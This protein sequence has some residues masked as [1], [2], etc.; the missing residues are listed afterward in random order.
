M[1]FCDANCR[2]YADFE[3][4][5]KQ[6]SPVAEATGLLCDFW[7]SRI[8]ESGGSLFGFDVFDGFW[9]D[10]GW[11]PGFEVGAW[12]ASWGVAVFAELA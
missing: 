11:D 7:L 2:L 6:S 5:K 12:P 10:G 3:S 4:T 9:G 8:R 1:M